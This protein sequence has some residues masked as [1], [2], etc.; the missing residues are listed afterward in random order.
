MAS[1]R[2]AQ[3]HGGIQ[4]RS[5]SIFSVTKTVMSTVVD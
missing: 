4:R 3:R 1:S 2:L 5:Q